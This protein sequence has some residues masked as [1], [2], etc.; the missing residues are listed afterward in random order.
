M[1]PVA[2]HLHLVNTARLLLDSTNNMVVHRHQDNMERLHH[3]KEDTHHKEDIRHN[4]SKAMAED[5]LLKARAKAKEAMVL[6]QAAR[7]ATSQQG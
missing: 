1:N 4:N 6:L 2:E 7:L 5:T 3:N